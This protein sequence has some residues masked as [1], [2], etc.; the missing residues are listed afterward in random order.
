MRAASDPLPPPQLP[1][2]GNKRRDKWR[3]WWWQR[4]CNRGA[5]R[6]CHRS[7]NPRPA[8]S[9]RDPRPRRCTPAPW[10]SLKA[11]VGEQAGIEMNGEQVPR[12]VKS[13]CYCALSSAARQHGSPD[14]AGHFPCHAKCVK[15]GHIRSETPRREAVKLGGARISPLRRPQ[16]AHLSAVAPERAERADA[17]G[18]HKRPRVRTGLCTGL[19]RWGVTNQSTFLFMHYRRSRSKNQSVWRR[20]KHEYLKTRVVMVTLVLQKTASDRCSVFQ[21][22]TPHYDVKIVHIT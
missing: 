10:S 21:S 22:T 16:C 11:E 1:W 4:R 12:S 20:A 14:D 5:K 13:L 6:T 2:G 18:F 19:E 15:V 9:D 7:R 17:C 8:C 3:R